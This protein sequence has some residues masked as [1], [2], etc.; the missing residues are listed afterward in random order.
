MDQKQVVPLQEVSDFD[1]ACSANGCSWTL[2]SL[3]LELRIPHAVHTFTRQSEC[4]S[5]TYIPHVYV[6]IYM[7]IGVHV[8]AYVIMQVGVLRALRASLCH[9]ALQV[10][11]LMTCPAQEAWGRPELRRASIATGEI[12][13]P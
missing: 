1:F 11:G 8:Y 13:A 2:I 10:G 6:Y 3:A 5:S 4:R 12:W 9:P 7:Y